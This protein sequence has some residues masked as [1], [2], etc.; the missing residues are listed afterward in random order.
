MSAGRR[1]KLIYVAFVCG[2]ARRWLTRVQLTVEMRTMFL[3]RSDKYDE[4]MY[5]RNPFKQTVV[6]TNDEQ[7]RV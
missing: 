7:Q 5:G 4:A 6:C 2:I 3:Q 1:T